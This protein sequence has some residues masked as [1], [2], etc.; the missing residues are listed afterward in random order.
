MEG[1]LGNGKCGPAW[2]GDNE[3]IGGSWIQGDLQCEVV[4]VGVVMV[5]VGL[6]QNWA[7]EKK[8]DPLVELQVGLK[9]EDLSPQLS[10]PV[11]EGDPWVEWQVDQL[12]KEG[13]P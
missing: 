5:V 12:V 13:D 11:K 2:V 3:V 6:I 7:V 10:P 4:T 1:D 9:G 8:G